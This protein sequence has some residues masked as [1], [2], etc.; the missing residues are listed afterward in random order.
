MDNGNT[1]DFELD[2]LNFD[3]TSEDWD[4]KPSNIASEHDPRA[5]GNKAVTAPEDNTDTAPQTIPTPEPSEAVNLEMPPDHNIEQ[6]VNALAP[7]KALDI[8]AKFKIDDKGLDAESE[9]KTIAYVSEYKNSND[10]DPDAPDKFYEG[11][12]GKGGMSDKAQ[13]SLGRN[14]EERG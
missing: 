9:R 2:K 1:Q 10:D 5:I 4:N 13:A 14:I 3:T 7:I 8:D 12:R 11:V 6:E